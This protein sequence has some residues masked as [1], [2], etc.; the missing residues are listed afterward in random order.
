[1]REFLLEEME[2]ITFVLISSEVYFQHFKF[3]IG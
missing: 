3:N 1:M 2:E